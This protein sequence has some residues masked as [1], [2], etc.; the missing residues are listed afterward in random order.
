MA[1][2]GYSSRL[3]RALDSD[4]LVAVVQSGTDGRVR[5][6]RLA[7]GAST[8]PPATIHAEPVGCGALRF[9]DG[10]PAEIKRVRV[11]PAVR[12]LGLGRRLLGELEARAACGRTRVLGLDTNRSLAEAIGLYPGG[13]LARGGR[14][15]RRAPCPS[16]VRKEAR[17]RRSRA[18]AESA[19]RRGLMGWV[20]L[21]TCSPGPASHSHRTYVLIFCMFEV[22]RGPAAEITRGPGGRL[23]S[24][25]A[26]PDAGVAGGRPLG[27]A[28]RAAGPVDPGPSPAWPAKSYPQLTRR[29]RTFLPRRQF[30]IRM[31]QAARW[32]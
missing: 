10:A 1:D 32:R 23:S 11:A 30:R 5:T 3:S 25:H 8:L 24:L 22:T 2:S 21:P 6:A 4:G 13:R 19:R 20:S 15:Q 9:H 17:R 18:R 12:R 16:L 26:V 29:A 28:A 14:A 7:P 27:P 31:A